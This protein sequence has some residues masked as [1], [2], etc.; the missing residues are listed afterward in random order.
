MNKIPLVILTLGL[1][2]GI[3]IIFMNGPGENSESVSGEPGQN[4]EI[5]DGVQYVTI[6]ARGGYSPRTTQI[7]GGFPTKLIVKTD[8]TYDCSAALVIRSLGFQKILSPE[9]EEIIDA[10]IPKSGEKIQGVCGMGMYS[11]QIDVS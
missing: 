5:R 3:G 2:I 7:Q 4:I 11:F 8:G 1:V 10:G 6:V 9:G